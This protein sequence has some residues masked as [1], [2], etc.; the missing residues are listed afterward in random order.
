M[1][2]P[3]KIAAIIVAGLFVYLSLY[4][5]NL[6]TGHLDALSSYTGLDLAGWIIR[7]G[8]W[9]SEQVTG[10]WDRYVYLVGLKQ[11]NDQLRAENA[12]IRLDNLMLMDRA[13]S[14]ERLERLLLFQPIPQWEAQ[15]ARIVAHR[16]GPATSLDTLTIDK[17]SLSGVEAD[18]PAISLD[19]VLGRVLRTGA[20]ASHV[21]LL[22][23]GNSRIAVMGRENR[24]QGI[25]FGQGRG[26]PLRIEYINLN[27]AIEPGELMITS[28]LA[29]IYPKGLPVARVTGVFRSDISLFL[30]VEAEPLVDVDSL[31]EILLLK[32]LPVPEQG[33]AN[34]TAAG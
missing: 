2:K 8:Q 1:T 16:L 12:K 34:A 22:S 18:M 33:D 31:E 13:G 10:F 15:G 21:L 26:E 30:T 25:L 23:D 20:S 5:W 3:K 7:P 27:S 14:T 6:R 9:V 24:S 32:R 17:G 4:T 11:E 28:G 19:G 29:G